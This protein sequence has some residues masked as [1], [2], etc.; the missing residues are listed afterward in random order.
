MKYHFKVHKED[1]GFWAECIEFPGCVTQ[2]ETEV[3][4][5][6]HMQEALNLY[7]DEPADSKELISLPDHTV[8]KSKNIVEV[9]LDPKLSFSLLVKHLRMKNGLTQREA[10]EKMGFDKIYSYQRLEAGKCNPSLKMLSKIKQLYPDF[11]VDYAI[12]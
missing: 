10:A 2:A 1:Q 6:L 7:V 9:P 8:K 3:T 12:F 5:F 11:S 4:L